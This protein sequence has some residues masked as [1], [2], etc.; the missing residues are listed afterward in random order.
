MSENEMICKVCMHQCHLREGQ[1][2]RCR[3]RKNENGISTPINYGRITSIALD[4]IEKKPLACFYPGS[5]IL[6][7]GS[8]GCNLNCPFCQN[9]AI[10]MAGQTEVESFFVTPEQLAKEAYAHKKEGNIGVAFTYNEPLVGYEFVRDTA[11]LVHEYK[12]KNVVVTNGSISKEAAKEF[13]PY[14]DAYNIDLKGFTQDYYDKLG[15]SLDYV[16]GFIAL[17]A[18][19]AH[20]EITTLIVPGENDSKEEIR[21]LAVWIASIDPD[22]PLHLTRFFPRRNMKEKDPTD[23]DL[24]YELQKEAKKYLNR[25]F[26][27]NV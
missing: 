14:I 23:V 17:A 27:G 1:I 2:G 20:V 6:S 18:E 21:N 12:M 4:P 5:M 3:A 15:G 26:V 8:F 24:L 10:A 25:V 11:K 13:L 19:H 22:M 9:D 16:K 7:V